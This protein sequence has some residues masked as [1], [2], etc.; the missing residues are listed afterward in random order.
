M[1]ENKD[2]KSHATCPN[3]GYT[4]S[5]TKQASITEGKAIGAAFSCLNC[6]MPLSYQKGTAPSHPAVGVETDSTGGVIDVAR[7]T[8]VARA[9]AE[10]TRDPIG[11]AV[12]S[13]LEALEAL[14]VVPKGA[15][16]R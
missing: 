10:G 13:T 8:Q 5:I 1:T 9:D 6:G 2:E 15:V 3:C 11:K 14:G 12:K 16:D 4:V 7:L